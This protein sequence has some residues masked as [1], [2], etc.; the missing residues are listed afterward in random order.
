MKKSLKIE[1][2]DIAKDF[3]YDVLDGSLDLDSLTEDSYMNLVK[4]R[5]K[6]SSKFSIEFLEEMTNNLQMI[7]DHTENMVKNKPKNR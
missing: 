6:D 4:S 3:M 2:I 1:A 7:V 5:M